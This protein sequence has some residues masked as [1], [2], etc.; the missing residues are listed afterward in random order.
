MDDSFDPYLS[1]IPDTYD[2]FDCKL[3]SPT[4]PLQFLQPHDN[5]PMTS[6]PKLKIEPKTSKRS[7]NENSLRELTKRFISLIISADGMI[8]DL[9]DAMGIL[10]VQ[11]RRIYDITNVLEG[12]GLIEKCAKNKIHWKS[13]LLP[14]ADKEIDDD[15]SIEKL[16]TEKLD[17][18][19]CEEEIDK[20]L[21]ALTESK[22]YKQYAYVTYNDIKQILDEDN[23]NMDCILIRAPKGAVLSIPT[24]S[25]VEKCIQESKGIDPILE[26]RKYQVHVNT[27]EGD[28]IAYGIRGTENKEFCQL[29]NHSESIV[30]LY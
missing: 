28:I 14:S 21:T 18:E 23:E 27:N 26:G 2:T 20:M 25:E 12:I 24:P 15:K 8:L 29:F 1:P 17:L 19:K 9:N 3:P 13:V 16:L 10:K 22:E 11:K 5:I 30:D 7:R 4:T 6:K